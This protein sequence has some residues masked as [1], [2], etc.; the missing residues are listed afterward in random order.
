[1][2]NICIVT[3]NNLYHYIIISKFIFKVDIKKSILYFEYSIEVSINYHYILPYETSVHQGSPR[4]FLS[5]HM[6]IVV[7]FYTFSL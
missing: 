3:C 7:I 1:M 5:I 4:P 6:E 2:N